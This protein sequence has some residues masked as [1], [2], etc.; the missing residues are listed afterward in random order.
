MELTTCITETI[1]VDTTVSEIIQRPRTSRASL[2]GTSECEEGFDHNEYIDFTSI[3]DVF[4]EASGKTPD[5]ANKLDTSSALSRIMCGKLSTVPSASLNVQSAGNKTVID[6]ADMDFTTCNTV[7][8]EVLKSS[9][10]VDTS[11]ALSRIMSSKST[12]SAVSSTSS[13]DKTQLFSIGDGEMEMTACITQKISVGDLTLPEVSK[14]DNATLGNKTQIFD[15]CGDMDFTA[16]HTG[17]IDTQG[18]SLSQKLDTGSALSRLM[19]LPKTDATKTQPKAIMNQTVVDNADMEFT[20]CLSATINIP[21]VEDKIETS[22]ALSRIMMSQQTS[23]PKELSSKVEEPPKLDSSSVLSRLSTFSSRSSTCLPNSQ[24]EGK[25]SLAN[26]GNDQSDEPKVD[27][28]SFLASLT[29]AKNPTSENMGNRTQVFTEDGDSG[30]MDFTACLTT[31]LKQDLATQDAANVTSKSMYDQTRVF[32]NGEDLEFTTCLSKTQLQEFQNGKRDFEAKTPSVS[33]TNGTRFDRTRLFSE[34]CDM[35]FTVCNDVTIT[36]NDEEETVGLPGHGDNAKE[37]LGQS[38]AQKSGFDYT[39]VFNTGEDMEMTT[40]LPGQPISSS[41]IAT[42]IGGKE[43]ATDRTRLYSQGSDDMEFTAQL[44]NVIVSGT[45]L[46]EQQKENSSSYQEKL[47]R[48]TTAGLAVRTDSP[49]ISPLNVPTPKPKSAGLSDITHHYTASDPSANMD[50][51]TCPEKTIHVRSSSTSDTDSDHDILQP[52]DGVPIRLGTITAPRMTKDGCIYTQATFDSTLKFIGDIDRSGRLENQSRLETVIE[53]SRETS[54]ASSVNESVPLH[55]VTHIEHARS[56]RGIGKSNEKQGKVAEDSNAT[57]YYGCDVSSRMDMTECVGGLVPLKTGQSTIKDPVNVSTFGQNKTKIFGSENDSGAMEMTTCSGKILNQTNFLEST[58]IQPAD[59]DMTNCTGGILERTKLASDS[60]KT[61]ILD[62]NTGAMEMTTCYGKILDTTKSQPAPNITHY[63]ANTTKGEMELTTCTIP[64]ST[65][66]KEQNKTHMYKNDDTAAM[67]M[68]TCYGEIEAKAPNKTRL[69]NNDET[70]AMEMTTCHGEIQENIMPAANKTRLFSN[71]EAAAMEMTTCQGE[72]QEN[73]MPAANKTRL[74]SSDE[75]AAMEMT[76]CKGE[77]QEN[78]MP[79]ANKTRL[80]SSDE[81]AAMEMT[82]CQG[83]IQENRMP[84]ANKTRLF[85]SDETAAMEMTMCQGEIQESITNVSNKT[86]LFDADETAAMEM[87]HCA[88]RILN[89]TR[90]S[91]VLKTMDLTNGS[92][93]QEGQPDLSGIHDFI[94]KATGGEKTKI[95]N[96]DETAAMEMTSCTGA[97]LDRTNLPHVHPSSKDS[98]FPV[99]GKPSE[100][101]N[102][103]KEKVALSTKKETPS[104][105]NDLDVSLWDEECPDTEDLAPLHL[106]SSSQSITNSKSS[107]A[108]DKA[109]S[110]HQNVSVLTSIATEANCR[111]VEPTSVNVA[112]VNPPNPEPHLELNVSEPRLKPVLSKPSGRMITEKILTFL[113][114]SFNTITFNNTTRFVPSAAHHSILVVPV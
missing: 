109:K 26:D 27:A 64:D 46:E 44:T 47:P 89:G 93:A 69:F 53:T 104:D 55:S 91:S 48:K 114:S 107:D 34:G 32:E 8:I 113:G 19:S 99:L 62:G 22:S 29:G 35:D 83:E 21:S 13:A 50:L 41:D 72:I 59:M 103:H 11:T 23:A 43:K 79:A 78:R 39:K 68:T 85:S 96:S 76:T 12:P 86:R 14:P 88:G 6:D 58:K 60:N 42:E 97:I 81:T 90:L 25:F 17:V 56:D 67:E 105:M 98:S 51:T 66:T 92:S 82:T 45:A 16:C 70:A 49:E 61:Q 3:D 28:K 33:A 2:R 10:K 5:P 63:F 71:D 112:M 87:T 37:E 57:R 106:S 4:T 73:R 111:T 18:T 31:N 52:D 20:T 100:N 77:I 102:S 30:A 75:T 40:C 84:A 108:L 65:T 36:V 95:F 38:V 54:N 80:F 74:F 94:D 7:D 24:H 1:T 101:L 110:G 15:D 9:A